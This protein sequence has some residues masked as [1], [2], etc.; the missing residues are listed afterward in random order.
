[1]TD[2]DFL[3]WATAKGMDADAVA[4]ILKCAA[5]PL[6]SKTVRTDCIYPP[7]DICDLYDTNGFGVSPQDAG[8]IFVGYCANGDPI[9]MDVAADPGSV[10]Y[11]D[12]EVMHSKPLREVAVRVADNL[13]NAYA[14]IVTDRDFAVDYYS[15]I[16]K[17]RG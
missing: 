4:V 8:F 17:I 12:H 3:D 15:A 5:M 13:R 1:M 11:V 14:S 10:W 16:T 6:K 2:S 7:E 9:A